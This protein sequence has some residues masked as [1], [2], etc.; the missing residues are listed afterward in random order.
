M[1]AKTDG[2]TE[3]EIAVLNACRNNDFGDALDP[4]EAPWS[5]AIAEKA[6]LDT[7][8]Y[9]GVMASLVKKGLAVVWDYGEK[10]RFDDQ[11][12]NL[13]EKARGIFQ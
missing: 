10:G 4:N 12:V 6:G 7:K 3:L 5:Y 9:R 13:T 11:V 2:L 1:V 8:T